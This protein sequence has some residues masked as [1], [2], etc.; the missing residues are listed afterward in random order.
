MAYVLGFFCADGNMTIGKR[1]NRFIEF[2]STDLSII[3]Q[4]R[5]A[6]KSEHKIGAR[7]IIRNWKP[8]FRLQIGSNKIF[9]DLTKFGLKPNKSK[10]MIYPNIPGKHLH[11]FV[12]G[13]FD[14]DGHVTAVAYSRNGAS[15]PKKLLL[16]GFT[17]GTKSFLERLWQSLGMRGVVSG[18][19]LYKQDGAYRLT[20]SIKDSL[21]LYKFLYK[22]PRNSLYLSRKKEVFE[23]FIL[24]RQNSLECSSPCHG[25]DRG[26][27]SR[28]A[29]QLAK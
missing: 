10:R 9:Q 26:F 18:G 25:E 22:D 12:R 17:C 4:I 24:G 14:G 3:Q 27:K 28:P 1:G 16:S 8:A 29:R 11:H 2:T 13:Y 7:K 6:M 20:F 23:R 21:A 19:T 15:R 5:S